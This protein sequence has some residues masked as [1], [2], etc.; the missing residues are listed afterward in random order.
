M[1]VTAVNPVVQYTGNGSQTGFS[2][3]FSFTTNTDIAVR[4]AGV[5][6]TL[7][8]H[9]T[10]SGSTV[11]MLSAPA[12]GAIVEIELAMP[13][14]RSTAFTQ[15]GDFQATAL[16]NNLDRV[17]LIPQ[18]VQKNLNRAIRIAPGY[19]LGT[20]EI[21]QT[22]AARANKALSFDGSGNITTVDGVLVVPST[23]TGLAGN[24]LRVKSDETGYELRTP[25]QVRSD[26]GAD[27]ASN[28]GS[29]TIGSARVSGSYTG[30]TGVGTIT[31]G[32]WQ[33]TVIGSAYISGSYTNVTGLGTITVGTWQGTTIGVAY[34]GT[35]TTTS[36]G[37]GSVV[38]SNTPTLVTPVLGAATA[39]TPS[40][41]D[42]STRVATTAYVQSAMAAAGA[43]TVT[44]V[45]F[46]A[47]NTGLSVSGSPVT[48]TGTFQIDATTASFGDNSVKVA[49]TAYADRNT[50]TGTYLYK[51]GFSTPTG[52]LLCDGNAVSR[53]TYANLFAEITRSSTVNMTIASPSVITWTSHPLVVGDKVSFETTGSLPTGLST[54]TNYFVVSTPTG[55]TFTVSTTAGG[56][57][58]NTTGS[59]SGTHTCRHN[60]FG[61]GNGSTTFN[62]PDGRNRVMVA[63]GG[64]LL[65]APQMSPNGDVLGATGGSQTETATVS[66]SGSTT[67]GALTVF[68]TGVAYDGPNITSGAA[69]GGD[70]QA[71]TSAHG[72]GNVQ[73]TGSTTGG[74]LSLAASGG[75]NPATN[76]QPTLI[77]GNW[78]IRT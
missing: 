69:A 1:A 15:G 32:T 54:G 58:V 40:G 35:G 63:P 42:N 13:I 25:A 33:G 22:P 21:A 61:C 43:G 11:T 50:P 14:N 78:Y 5:L 66:V 46:N 52:W 75:T 30:I 16:E 26:I 60:P 18:Q 12:N 51:A 56:S 29:G 38:L 49:T 76:V 4:V 9:Y 44:N 37:S 74:S 24:M 67:G 3:P 70:F 71:G 47:G 39:T 45:A 72:H 23:L 41:G 77:G 20:L 65:T 59:Q 2:I 34:G 62:L 7:T 6:K 31:A 10:I 17:T 53:S 8:T 28:L 19:V 27:N 55:N 64:G 36:T 68:A 48:T 57:A 73:V